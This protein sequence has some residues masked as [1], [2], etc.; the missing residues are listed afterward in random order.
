MSVASRSSSRRKNLLIELGTEELPPKALKNLAHVFSQKFFQGLVSAGLVDDNPDSMKCYAAPRRLAVWVKGV[1]PKQLDKIEERR[2]P[3]LQAAYD[4]KGKP[5][6]A[7]HGFA[8]S[9]GVELSKLKT[10]KSEKGEWLIFENKVKGNKLNVVVTDC[11]FESIKSLP[12]PKRM[13]WG[14]GQAEFV[15]P[16][17]WLLALYGSDLIKTEVL[18]LK[19]DRFTHGH[20]FHGA[21]QINIPSADRYASTLK[22]NGYVVADFDERKT[23]ITKQAYRLANKTNSKVVIDQDLLDEVTGLVEWPV[24]LLGE[25]D[26]RFLKL[27][28]EVLISTM[29]KHQKYFHIVNDKNKPVSMFVAVSNIKSKSPKRVRQGNE[30]VLRARLSDAE[31]FWQADQK[32]KLEDRI[33]SLKGVLFHHKLGSIFDKS[34]RIKAMSQWIAK[35]LNAKGGLDIELDDV[36]KASLLCKADLVTDMVGEFPELQGV[37]GQYYA[38]SQ[39]VAKPVADAIN[40]HYMPRFAGDKLPKTAIAQCVALADRVDTLFG[41]FAC[42]EI[43]TG[44]KDPFALRRAAL[45]VLRIIIE[46]K[47]DLDLHKMYQEMAK[48]YKKS[49]IKDINLDEDTVNQ[50]YE[51]TMDRAKSYFQSQSFSIQEYHAVAACNPTKPLDFALRIKA[52]HHF[53]NKRKSSAVSLASANKRIANIL[54]KSNIDS[55]SDNFDSSLMSDAGEKTLASKINSIGGKVRKCFEQGEYSQ[56]LEILVELKDPV[57]QFFDN[58]M[59]MHDDKKIRHNRLALL[60]RVRQLFLGV[61]DIS[62]ASV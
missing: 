11:L 61:A 45:G 49:Q 60:G 14:E 19:S 57:D 22:T 52:V 50:V 8:K 35:E 24:A 36:H 42:G 7:A 53:F 40:T 39:G 59:V 3:A 55:R 54:S 48:I 17:H 33:E 34:A 27:P 6:P 21:G 23:L 58:V 38:N 29:A 43:P 1:S 2:G 62:K 25:F 18:G 28:R 15:R 31:F 51:F 44:D 41:I 10:K 20:R 26:S 56:G 9:C 47:L 37:I 13:R 32:I 46:N 4:E 5:T 30:R 16:V 12:I